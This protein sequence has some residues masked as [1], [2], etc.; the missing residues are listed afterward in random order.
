MV[1][2]GYAFLDVDVGLAAFLAAGFASCFAS[3]ATVFGA[4]ALPQ[5]GDSGDTAVVIILAAV[6]LAARL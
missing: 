4:S 6:G 2:T 5:G 3:T 1:G